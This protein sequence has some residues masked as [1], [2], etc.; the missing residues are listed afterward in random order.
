MTS[1]REPLQPMPRKV[2]AL[3]AAAIAVFTVVLVAALWWGGT[4]G[5]SG[6]E[7][8]TA[9]LDALRTGLSIGLGGGGLFALYLA[10]RR[11]HATEVGLV[12]AERVAVATEKDAADRRVTELYAKSSEQL[13]SDKA[14]VRLAGIYALERLAQEVPEQRQTIVNLLCA[15]LR[16]PYAPPDDET[17]D[18]HRERVQERE[19][20]RTAQQV[21]AAH[22]RPKDEAAFWGEAV[23]VNLGGATLIDADFSDCRFGSASFRMAT[24]VDVAY[25]ARAEFTGEARFVAAKFET[26]ASFTAVQFEG[27]ALFTGATFHS[28]GFR[29]CRFGGLAQFMDAKF[30]TYGPGF[31]GEFA[32]VVFEKFVTFQGAQF[33]GRVDFGGARVSTGDAHARS[34]WPDDWAVGEDGAFAERPVETSSD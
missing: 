14:P 2:I 31:V 6:K 34:I 21:L 22:L 3:V 16:M 26:L 24:F 25:F 10:W 15:Y 20:R 17:D 8:V 29:G 27:P 11:R 18:D 9:R 13:G 33:D 30:R 23:E 32:D 5:L 1:S 12:H 19:V 4:A 7:L 28:V